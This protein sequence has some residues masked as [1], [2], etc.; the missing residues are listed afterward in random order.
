MDKSS[1]FEEENSMVTEWRELMRRHETRRSKIEVE[2][3]GEGMTMTNYHRMIMNLIPPHWMQFPN[4]SEVD[5]WRSLI[6]PWLHWSLKGVK[7]ANIGD[8]AVITGVTD[9]QA[10]DHQEFGPYR[11]KVW[12]AVSKEFPTKMNPGKLE[13]FE[14]DGKDCAMKRVWI[15]EEMGRGDRDLLRQQ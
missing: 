11:T 9:S 12:D 2:Q 5:V 15:P 6:I 1:E 10:Y 7:Y 14:M 13:H 4:S 8:S 3:K